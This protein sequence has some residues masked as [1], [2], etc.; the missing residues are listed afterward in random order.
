MTTLPTGGTE[1]RW[2]YTMND[3]AA[4]ARRVVQT[5]PVPNI[6]GL[7]ADMTDAAW[8]AIVE[9]LCTATRR[10]PPADLFLAAQQ[11]AQQEHDDHGRHHG[12]AYRGVDSKGGPRPR[13]IA[14]WTPQPMPPPETVV[15]DHLTLWAI[16][17]T[18]TPTDQQ[19]LIALAVHGDYRLAA[20]TLGCTYNAFLMRI[21]KAR[22]RFRQL[23][24]EGETPSAMWGC[25]RRVGAYTRGRRDSPDGPVNAVRERQRRNA[26][27]RAGRP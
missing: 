11:A 27:R 1:I 12:D 10:P 21:N 26:R 23:W 20:A 24:H 19:A 6:T 8:H 25:D 14:Y 15:V 9:H 5:L 18:L 13:F 7:G 3:A 2:G 16:W 4:I 22:R 17:A